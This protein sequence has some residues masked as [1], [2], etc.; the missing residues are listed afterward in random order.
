[1]LAGTGA[2]CDRQDITGGC[3][4]HMGVDTLTSQ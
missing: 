3:L 1:M 2:S 4:T